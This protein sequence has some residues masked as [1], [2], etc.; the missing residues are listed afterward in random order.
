MCGWRAS[1]TFIP[2]S[3]SS[4]LWVINLSGPCILIGEECANDEDGH[5]HSVDLAHRPK[6]HHSHARAHAKKVDT[7]L[8]HL[9][10][11]TQGPSSWLPKPT[12]AQ[13]PPEHL[14][15]GTTPSRRMELSSAA[16]VWLCSFLS[17]LQ[18]VDLSRSVFH[19]S[20][21]PHL[22]WKHTIEKENG[23]GNHLEHA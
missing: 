12:L 22:L 4:N 6:C 8:P 9:Y 17:V 10:I 23:E 20:E 13:F 18:L 3:E 21:T 5:C 19:A 11:P 1:T 14:A 15:L 16:G 2:K 7:P